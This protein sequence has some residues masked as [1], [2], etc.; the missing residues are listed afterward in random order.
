MAELVYSPGYGSGTYDWAWD[1]DGDGLPDRELQDWEYQQ[2]MLTTAGPYAPAPAGPSDGAPVYSNTHIDPVT[3]ELKGI[4]EKTGRL[5]V[6]P[7]A[8]FGVPP[9]GG[10]GAGGEPPLPFRQ[11]LV[12]PET[13]LKEVWLLDPRTG[14]PIQNLGLAEAPS[15]TQGLDVQEVNGVWGVFMPSDTPGGLPTFQAIP[16]IPQGAAKPTIIQRDDG[17]Y[18]ISQDPATGQFKVQLIIPGQPT[19][20]PYDMARQIIQKYAGSTEAKAPGAI[21][22]EIQKAVDTAFGPGAS[23]QT[24][25]ARGPTEAG[26]MYNP[27]AA[28]AIGQQQGTTNLGVGMLGP[29]AAGSV[30]G[31]IAM[32][33]DVSRYTGTPE[34]QEAMMTAAGLRPFQTR[35]S[36][37]GEL[38]TTLNLAE[39][40][41]RGVEG[42]TLPATSGLGAAVTGG[43][44]PRTAMTPT[45]Y[46]AAE[47]GV[48]LP[49]AQPQAGGGL[50]GQLAGAVNQPAR[51]TLATAP[52]RRRR[53]TEE[54][55]ASV[56]QSA[57]KL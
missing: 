51:P 37:Y 8:T 29:L 21:A 49:Y 46:G 45:G 15:A 13:G 42:G 18:A 52:R 23:A 34:Q 31:N 40:A 41:R 7:G 39:A 44:V 14:T 25:F 30:S 54:T 48:A 16:G 10:G 9:R 4:N 35:L 5:E 57:I 26:G 3:G 56:A 6:V 2:L 32:G 36:P 50:I 1:D 28:Q 43:P 20:S 17:T 53:S 47:P 38:L 12:N 19:G 55:L 27:A 22:D 33:G 11:T 24:V